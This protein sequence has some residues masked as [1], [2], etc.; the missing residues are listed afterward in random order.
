MTC[1]PGWETSGTDP[2]AGQGG[3]ERRG[4]QASA[5]A[6]GEPLP[7]EHVVRLPRAVEPRCEA[8]LASA[9]TLQLRLKT[10]P[11]DTRKCSWILTD[12]PPCAQFP[13]CPSFPKPLGLSLLTTVEMQAPREPGKGKG[14]VAGPST[15][16]S[17]TACPAQG[18]ESGLAGH[19][20]RST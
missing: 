20:E 4:N 10:F 6:S 8:T 11:G 5:R 3:G 18:L 13:F 16:Y 12:Q 2:G 14:R 1:S 15:S 9:S 7:R 17:G 19:V